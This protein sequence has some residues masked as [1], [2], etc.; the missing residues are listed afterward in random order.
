MSPLMHDISFRLDLPQQYVITKWALKT[1]MVHD[2]A[3]RKRP[4]CYER[5]MCESLRSRSVIPPRTTVWLSRCAH[6]KGISTFITD[7]WLTVNNA[8]KGAHGCVTTLI[9]GYLAIQVLTVV[10]LPENR[11]A[12]IRFNSKIGP[13]AATLIGIWPSGS[14]VTWPPTLSF[15][16]AHPD[17]DRLSV[18]HLFD[19]WRIGT[20]GYP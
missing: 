19:R 9:L 2:A 20:Q 8:P 6:P 3:A 16:T 17:D 7:L 13:W 4:F 18:Y 12:V 11:D 1:A 15:T 10:P 5:Q 14:N